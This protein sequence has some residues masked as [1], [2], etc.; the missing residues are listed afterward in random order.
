[1]KKPLLV[2][3]IVFF[4]IALLVAY[5]AYSNGLFGLGEEIRDALSK[6]GQDEFNLSEGGTGGCI[7]ESCSKDQD[8]LNQAVESANMTPCNNITDPGLKRDCRLEVLEEMAGGGG[9]GDEQP[10]DARPPEDI[11]KVDA[12]SAYACGSE[13]CFQLKAY[14]FNTDA[15]DVSGASYY[16]NDAK[17]EAVAWDGGVG[18]SACV[19]ARELEQGQT[20]FG[21]L[22][23]STCLIGDV[24]R[25]S[26]ESGSISWRVLGECE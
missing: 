4:V 26:F 14:D 16:V 7:N 12:I 24:F 9:E 6:G 21:K 11:R 18:E 15:V 22:L 8:Y 17:K 5:L 2:A 13:I 10:A 23:D 3:I 19:S 20:C 1:M 25:A